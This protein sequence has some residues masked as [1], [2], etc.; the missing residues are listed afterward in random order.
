VA[1]ARNALRDAGIAFQGV[2]PDARSVERSHAAGAD[3]V[4]RNTD[5]QLRALADDSLGGA[6]LVGSPLQATLGH[7]SYCCVSCVACSWRAVRS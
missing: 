3:A 1:G 4:Q 5:V 7:V 2:D 6:V